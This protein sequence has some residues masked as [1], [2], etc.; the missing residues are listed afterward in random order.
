MKYTFADIRQ[1]QLS[2]F[3]VNLKRLQ[4]EEWETIEELPMIVYYSLFNESAEEAGWFET[5]EVDKAET[6]VGDLTHSQAME[7]TKA[8]AEKY[9]E[10]TALDPN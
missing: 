9:T 1:R 10:L 2:Q 6:T 7:L 8:V 5:L 3:I 4:P